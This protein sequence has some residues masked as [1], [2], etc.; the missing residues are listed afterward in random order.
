MKWHKALRDAAE[1]V[2]RIPLT[3]TL[4]IAPTDPTGPRFRIEDIFPCVDGGR[5]AVKRIAG[6]MVE[7]WADIFRE[8]HDILGAAVL[9]RDQ[10]ADDWQRE[11]M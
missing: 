2:R 4:E 9:W 7:I 5:Y 10:D 3:G 11:P 8:G 1:N 6:E